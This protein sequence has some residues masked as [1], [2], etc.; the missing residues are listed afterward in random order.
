[1]RKKVDGFGDTGAVGGGVDDQVASVMVQGRA[2]V[3]ALFAVRVPGGAVAGWFEDNNFATRRC[4]GC[5]IEIE[6]AE[7]LGIRREPRIDARLSE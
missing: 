5:T 7:K 3:P 1:M 6:R 2:N 4:E